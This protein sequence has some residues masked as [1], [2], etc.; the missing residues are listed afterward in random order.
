MSLGEILENG[1]WTWHCGSCTYSSVDV[2][3]AGGVLTWVVSLSAASS[4][5]V[6]RDA[7]IISN[8]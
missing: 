6:I 5:S 3:W 1:G 2:I 4:S 8:T 7:Y